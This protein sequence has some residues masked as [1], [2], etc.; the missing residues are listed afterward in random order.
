[1]EDQERG[2]REASLDSKEGSSDTG[3]VKML[4]WRFFAALLQ[5][6]GWG[7][8]QR[9]AGSASGSYPASRSLF[10]ASATFSW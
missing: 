4:V 5:K 6:L 3:F 1:M 9:W 10:S 2:R 7:M 8:G